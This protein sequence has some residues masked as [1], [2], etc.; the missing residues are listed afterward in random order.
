MVVTDVGE[1]I[2]GAYLKLILNCDIVD[3]NVRVPGGGKL[4]LEE[5]DVIGLKFDTKQA[6]LCEVTTH[7]RGVLYTNNETTIKKIEDKHKRQIS[8][9]EKFLK[10]FPNRRY[11]FWAPYVP[12][13]GITDA[14]FKI[15]TLD[16]VINKDYTAS[17]DKLRIEAKNTTHLTGNDF[18]RILQILEHLK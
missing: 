14:L 7:L 6:F 3:Y 17:I 8:Y 12:K 4:G 11:M 16:L 1:L 13:G 9:A 2:V 18:F 15:N 5:L 10:D